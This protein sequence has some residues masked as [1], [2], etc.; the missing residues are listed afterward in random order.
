MNNTS[1]NL[2]EICGDLGADILVSF[3]AKYVGCARSFGSID[4]NCSNLIDVR[5]LACKI[6]WVAS[7]WKQSSHRAD[8]FNQSNHVTVLCWKI[9]HENIWFI[10]VTGH[11]W[12][13]QVSCTATVQHRYIWNLSFLCLCMYACT[14]RARWKNLISEV[15]VRWPLNVEGF[16]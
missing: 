13:D 8:D 4:F 14:A 16:S 9:V 15:L 1:G 3:P 10:V 11:G 7:S 6:G 5:I 12:P 2:F